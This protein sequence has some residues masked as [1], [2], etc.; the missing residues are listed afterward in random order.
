MPDTK[1]IRSDI[2]AALGTLFPG[3]KNFTAI[4]TDS[5]L[6]SFNP[7]TGG[8]QDSDKASKTPRYLIQFQVVGDKLKAGNFFTTNVTGKIGY[9]NASAEQG[10]P[11]ALIRVLPVFIQPDGSFYLHEPWEWLIAVLFAQSIQSKGS[12]QT[13]SNFLPPNPS[14]TW[15]SKKKSIEI[16]IKAV[17]LYGMMSPDDVHTYLQP[18]GTAPLPVSY[19]DATTA[20]QEYLTFHD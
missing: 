8:W 9:T 1:P 7:E 3:D 10:V 6:P 18:A 4:G 11:G 13:L 15:S 2:K 16:P 14:I 12:S 17:Q 19:H 5:A 20:L